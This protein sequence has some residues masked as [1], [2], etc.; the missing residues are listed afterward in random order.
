MSYEDQTI[1]LWLLTPPK[2]PGTRTRYYFS[3]WA[4]LAVANA[5]TAAAA[6]VSAPARTAHVLAPTASSLPPAVVALSLTALVLGPTFVGNI[7]TKLVYGLGDVASLQ[8]I[9]FLLLTIILYRL[10]CCSYFEHFLLLRF[11]LPK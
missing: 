4:A 11:C 6:T 9:W 10:P 5:A 1:D 8:L 7:H 2:W 3:C